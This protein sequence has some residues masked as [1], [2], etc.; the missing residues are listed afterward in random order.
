MEAVKKL[1]AEYGCVQWS[2]MHKNTYYNSA[3]HAYFDP[4]DTST[5]H[6]ITVVG[7][8]DDYPLENFSS[9]NRPGSNGAWIVKNSWGAAWGENGYFYI[10]YEDTSIGSANPASVS[11]AALPDTYDNN[12]FHGNTAYLPKKLSSYKKV[13]QVYQIQ[14][15]GEQLEAISVMLYSDKG[16]IQLIYRKRLLWQK[17]IIWQL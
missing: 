3:T 17:V 15:A 6:A 14:S 13:S 11:V 8:D 16:F 10:S 4:K 7:W 1:I 12:Y 5:N 2:Y 9:T